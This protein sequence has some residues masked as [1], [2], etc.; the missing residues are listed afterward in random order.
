MNYREN[1]RLGTDIN[2]YQNQREVLKQLVG[3]LFLRNY[4]DEKLS[5]RIICKKYYQNSKMI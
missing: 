1:P 5:I 2:N 3:M 4:S